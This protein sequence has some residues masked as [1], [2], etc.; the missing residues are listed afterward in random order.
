[1]GRGWKAPPAGNRTTRFKGYHTFRDTA[2]KL[3]D[4]AADVLERKLQEH[5][6]EIGGA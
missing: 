3:D 5:L 6:S 1:V 4:Q 2:K